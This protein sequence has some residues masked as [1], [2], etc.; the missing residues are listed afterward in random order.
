MSAAP[1]I[2]RLLPLGALFLAHGV[3]LFPATVTTVGL[4]LYSVIFL[5][6]LDMPGLMPGLVNRLVMPVQ[7]QP[8]KPVENDLYGLVR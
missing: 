5:I 4:V 3:E 6:A 7:A 2:H 1:V 8:R